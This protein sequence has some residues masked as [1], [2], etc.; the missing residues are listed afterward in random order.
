MM[1]SPRALVGAA[2]I[3]LSYPIALTVQLLYGRGADTVIHFVTGAGFVIFAMSVFDF[4]LP[5]WVSVIGGG[6]AGAFGTIFVLQGVSD[7]T[8]HEGLGFV[9]FDLLGHHVERLLPDVI[10]VW[11]VALLLLSSTGRSR[12]LGWAVMVIVVGQEVALL[13]GYL[14]GVPIQSV[15]VLV[16]LPFLWLLFESVQPVSPAATRRSPYR[17][18]SSGIDLR[19]PMRRSACGKAS[20]SAATHHSSTS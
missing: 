7:V 10:Y 20:E 9:A 17:R 16:L 2:T 3:V 4:G 14:A 13:A 12:I 6:A 15:K 5:R 11:F 8:R 19:S 18:Q 1:R